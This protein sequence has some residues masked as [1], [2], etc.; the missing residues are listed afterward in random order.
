MK[1][2]AI[3]IRGK[4]ISRVTYDFETEILQGQNLSCRRIISHNEYKNM[5]DQTIKVSKECGY[6]LTFEMEGERE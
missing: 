3:V 6:K 2:R 1:E 4:T 5:K